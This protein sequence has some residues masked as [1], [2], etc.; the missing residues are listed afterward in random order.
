[1]QRVFFSV[2]ALVGCSV[3]DKSGLPPSYNRG[4]VTTN[5]IA[6]MELEIDAETSTFMVTAEAREL[7]AIEQVHR[8]N[9]TV[10]FDW[11]DWYY[12][13]TYITA[14]V[15]P[16]STDVVLNWP[17][18]AEDPQLT[19]GD[20][21]VSFAAVNE[22]GYPLD[23]VEI[24]VTVQTKADPDFSEGT[25]N[26]VI[27]YA[28]GIGTMADIVTAVEL[29][30]ERWHDVWA[31]HGLDVEVR[32]TALDIDKHL[33]YVGSGHPTYT[34]L[35][36]E[37][38]ED[39][40]LMVI[41]ESIGGEQIFYGVS[42]NIPGSLI[43]TPRSAVQL[44]WLANT[45]L[46][47]VF[48]DDDIRLMGETMAHEVSHYMGLFHPVE[49]TFGAWDAVSDTPKCLSQTVCES[50]LGGNLMYPYPVCS[51]TECTPQETLTDVQVGISH[52]Y[53]GTL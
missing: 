25:I 39:E 23:D 3:G 52:R 41:G 49:V 9:G 44:S 18:R 20:W 29:A 22:D 36:S 7:I 5:G 11:M 33:P 14:A 4:L 38:G 1:M 10:A 35:S 15:W 51:P 47:G 50:Q 26:V 16:L 48:S 30:V 31:P 12:E 24:E 32:Y 6:T 27:G 37:I 8:P 43:S 40:V 21:E 17:I 19:A 42:G 53:T 2:A 46:D 45:G 34:E 13:D 28:D